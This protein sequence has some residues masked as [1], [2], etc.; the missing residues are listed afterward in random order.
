M[1]GL[2]LAEGVDRASVAPIDDRAVSDLVAAGLLTATDD[3]I[4]L[5]TAGMRLASAVTLELL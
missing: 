2:R 3:R 5:T 1:M 4:A